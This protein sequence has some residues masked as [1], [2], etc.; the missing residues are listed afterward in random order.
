MRKYIYIKC[1]DENLQTFF[2]LLAFIEKYSYLH[3]FIID[4]A[5]FKLLAKCNFHLK[6]EMINIEQ[7]TTDYSQ[8]DLLTDH[9]IPIT[10]LNNYH[11]S[12]LIFPRLILKRYFKEFNSKLD[13]I[14]FKGNLSM[15]RIIDS[16]RLFIENKDF[17]ALYILLLNLFLFNKEFIINTKKSYFE[18]TLNGRNNKIKY[19]D[20]NYFNQMSMYK[21]IFCPRGDFLWT[22]RF[23]ETIQVGSIPICKIKHN[24]YEDFIF[25][26][27]ICFKKNN[28]I[29]FKKLIKININNFSKIYYV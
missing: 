5:N 16:F 6:F 3:I 8:I 11:T 1:Y 23:F 28:Y 22:Y 7:V 27:T 25:L 14:F 15:P 17:L 2:A 10:N 19:L 21:Y 20:P 26:K 18:F 13:K 9:K 4:N 29:Y 12:P 24:I